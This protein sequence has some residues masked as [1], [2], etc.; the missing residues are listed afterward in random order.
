VAT[1]SPVPP[2]VVPAAPARGSV[3]SAGAAPAAV[4]AAAAEVVREVAAIPASPATPVAGPDAATT[5]QVDVP[6]YPT[7][8]P[9]AGRWR[10]RLQRGLLV[11]SAELDW[12]PQPDARYALQLQGWVAGLSMPDWLSQGQLDAAGIAPER[13]VA[14]TSVVLLVTSARG[15]ADVWTF[16]V[17]GIEMVADRPALKLVREPRRLCAMR[18]EVWLDPAEHH[19]PLRAVQSPT[20]GGV[21]LALQRDEPGG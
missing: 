3:P 6:V 13:Y 11:G 19:L 12:A 5:G 21:A 9:P 15:D 1:A 16:V 7:R 8:M 17:Q 20:G 18:A 10:Y 2:A 4:A 14:G